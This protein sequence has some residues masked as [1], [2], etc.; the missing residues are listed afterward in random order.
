M[1]ARHRR[2]FPDILD[3][4][5]ICID[6]GLGFEDAIDRVARQAVSWDRELGAD[7]MRLSAEIK[8]GRPVSDALGAFAVRLGVPDIASF[9]TTLGQ[10]R[11][12]GV[13]VSVALR[14]HVEDFRERRLIEAE[15]A[16]QKMPAKLVLPIAL[17]IFP[18]ILVIIM[19]PAVLSFTA[20]TL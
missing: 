4:I 3:W 10:W 18:V 14:G 8:I 16:A 6:S 13:S 20:L 1:S 2:A 12:L 9:A 15:A 11:E 5:L 17:F 19:L 7:W